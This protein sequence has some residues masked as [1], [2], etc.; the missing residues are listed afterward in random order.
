M[1]T[2]AYRV[3]KF[4]D[5]W[6]VLRN[7]LETMDYQT[8]EAAFEAAVLSASGDLRSGHSVRIEIVAATDSAGARTGGGVP[9]T[10]DAF[11]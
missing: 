6:P 1:A 7:G 11:S 5:A 4:G 3:T 2:V 8:Q 9:M 10:G